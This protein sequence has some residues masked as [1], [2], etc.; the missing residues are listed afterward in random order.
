MQK[1]ANMKTLFD[2][3]C[4][5]GLKEIYRTKVSLPE[6]STCIVVLAEHMLYVVI[7]LNIT[8]NINHLWVGII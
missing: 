6:M 1:E 3:H 7:N 5:Q 2:N 8:Y 4:S